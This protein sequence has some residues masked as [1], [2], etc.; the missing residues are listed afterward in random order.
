MLNSKN[1]NQLEKWKQVA[2][3]FHKKILPNETKSSNNSQ[4]DLEF[5]E[6]ERK[7]AN[8]LGYADVT[9]T[10]FHRDSLGNYSLKS[11]TPLAQFSFWGC[12]VNLLIKLVFLGFLLTGYL[13]PIPFLDQIAALDYMLCG[14]LPAI[15]TLIFGFRYPLHGIHI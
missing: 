6:Y 11:T 9:L 1:V 8:R 14:L 12:T 4:P 10:R 3:D 13:G 15:G 7:I 5:C 2:S